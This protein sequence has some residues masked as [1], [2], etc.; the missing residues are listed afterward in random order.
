L[1][2][3]VWRAAERRGELTPGTPDRRRG[4]RATPPDPA[5]KRVAQLAEA[6]VEL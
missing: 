6:I 1:H 3:A 2:L 5:A 4:P